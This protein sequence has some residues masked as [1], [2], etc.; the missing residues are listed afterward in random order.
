M[1]TSS[2]SVVPAPTASH[3]KAL[4]RLRDRLARAAERMKEAH[5]R[6]LLVLQLDEAGN[7]FSI[8]F[9]PVRR[10]DVPHVMAM[11]V[12]EEAAVSIL[13]RVGAYD[14]RTEAALLVT[15]RGATGF[16]FTFVA[17]ALADRPFAGID[18]LRDNGTVH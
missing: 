3:A 4:A 1:E 17:L 5:G 8:G 15:E 10:A 9:T 18:A 12:P 16:R 7:R 11:G 13:E 14:L 2:P 6:G